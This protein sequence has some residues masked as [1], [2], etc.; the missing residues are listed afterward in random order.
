MTGIVGIESIQTTCALWQPITWS[1]H[2]TD[3]TI[4]GVK[5]N[6]AQRDAFCKGVNDGTE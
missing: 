4:I 3:Q 2:D 5:V 1:V 6:N